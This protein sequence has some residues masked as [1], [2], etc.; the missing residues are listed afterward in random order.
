MKE[1]MYLFRGGDAREAQQSPDAMQAHM[2]KWRT[3]MESLAKTGNLV[4]GLPLQQEGKVVAKGGKVI[5]DGP[6]TEGK[7]VVGGYL[8]VKAKDLNEAASL[9]NGC[10]IYEYDGTTEVREIMPI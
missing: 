8:I 6:F 9:A 3:W 10:P 5:T 4:T 2:Q 1:F 7:E